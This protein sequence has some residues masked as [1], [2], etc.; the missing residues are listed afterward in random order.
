M[1]FP[2]GL[3]SFPKQHAHAPDVREEAVLQ[4]HVEHRVPHRH[5]QRVA[6]EGGAVGADRHALGGLGRG[7]AGAQGKAAADALGNGHDV[8]RDVRPFVGEQLARAPDACLDFVHDEKQPVPVAEFPE[9][10]HPAWGQGT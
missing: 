4:D 7:E 8:G 9:L 2:E 3:K 1:P 10:A 6:A 5:G